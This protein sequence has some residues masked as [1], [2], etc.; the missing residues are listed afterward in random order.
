MADDVRL[1]EL[2]SDVAAAYLANHVVPPHELAA[3]F[4]AISSALRA[5]GEVEPP[6]RPADVSVAR[7]TPAQIRKSIQGDGL[8]SFEDGKSYRTLKRHLT[9]F[10]LTPESYKA[11]WGL[12]ADYPMTAP[13]Y[14][15]T[16]RRLAL[17]RGLGRKDAAE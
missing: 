14:S 8:I 2:T 3:V 1:L 15:D 17:E 11:K 12:P 4:Q 7:L 13:S 6:E 9:R 5:V 16:R 10:G